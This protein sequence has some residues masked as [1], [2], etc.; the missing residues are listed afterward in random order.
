MPETVEAETIRKTKSRE[1]QLA[2]ILNAYFTIFPVRVEAI[3][4]LLRQACPEYQRRC[5]HV[6]GPGTQRGL[7]RPSRLHLPI[8]SISPIALF[9][10][11]SSSLFSFFV[12][13]LRFN[14]FLFTFFFPLA[15]FFFL[16][17]FHNGEF[18]PLGVVLTILPKTFKTS[19]IE[20]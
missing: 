8:Y 10:F 13:L 15:F 9:P 11:N 14:T 17:I 16:L 7:F 12:S 20:T 19:S 6:T 1:R 4:A 5:W 18:S 3:S 2:L